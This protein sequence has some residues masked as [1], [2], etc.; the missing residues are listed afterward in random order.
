[1]SSASPDDRAASAA[2]TT[3]A[4]PDG[5]G[6]V[7]FDIDGTLVDSNYLHVQAWALTF[8]EAGH[9]VE[10]WRIHRSIGMGSSQLLGE[11]LGDDVDRL[12]EQVT[13]GHSA[14]YAQMSDQ[15]R[16]FD[17]ARELVRAISQR[18]ALAVLSTSAVPDELE[19]LRDLLELEEVLDAVTGAGD[20]QDAKPEPELV[21]VALDKAGVEAGRAVFVGDSVWDVVA[22]SRAG[23]PTVGLRTGGSSEAELLAAGAVAVYDGPAHLLA[24]LDSSPLAKVWG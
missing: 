18:G 6:A 7:I 10:S 4:G 9:P 21:Q 19:R 1:M 5:P 2:T 12:H 11:L 24:E 8:A 22:A 20:V 14:R 13:E 17:G 3:T 15:L 16:A 23:V